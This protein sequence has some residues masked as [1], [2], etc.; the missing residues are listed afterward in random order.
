MKLY[1]CYK[2]NLYQS[3]MEKLQAI[4]DKIINFNW[5]Y[6]ERSYE[7]YLDQLH[8]DKPQIYTKFTQKGSKLDLA[9]L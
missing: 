9:R 6:S 5:N 3:Y 1:Q 8:W 4:L 7:S 2:E